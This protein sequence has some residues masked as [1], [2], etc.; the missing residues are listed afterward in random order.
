MTPTPEHHK[1]II[2]TLFKRASYA[3]SGTFVGKVSSALAG[4]IIARSLGV[5]LFGTYS[6]LWELVLLCASITETGLTIGIQRDGAGDRKRL[7][8]L[9]GNALFMRIVIGIVALVIAYFFSSKLSRNPQA[10][11]IYI[12][13]SIASLVVIVSEPL[14]SGMLALGRQK[15]VAAFES[16]RGIVLLVGVSILMLCHCGVIAL[17]MLQAA[18]YVGTLIV[19]LFISYRHYGLSINFGSMWHAFSTSFI[20]GIS[21]QLYSIYSRAPIVLLA[22]FTN[23]KQ[24]GYF[25]A[26]MRVVGIAQVIGGGMYSRAFVP[27]LFEYIKISRDKFNAASRFMFVYFTLLGA[28][29]G[30]G[31]FVLAEPIILILMGKQYHESI[32][33]LRVLAFAL[34][35]IFTNFAPDAAM[36]AGNKNVTKVLFQIFGPVAGLLSGPF[37]IHTFQAAGAAYTE[38]VIM[39]ILLTLFLT[40][41]VKEH[42]VSLKKL[43]Q[44]G[45]PIIGI[46]LC[47]AICLVVFKHSFVPLIAVF[48]CSSS[49]ILWL[50]IKR[51]K[52]FF[53][54]AINPVA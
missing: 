17:A 11:L 31:L 51:N 44:I 43:L 6:A 45:F 50:W 34:F 42:F 27:S 15:T 37:L 52:S 10:P 16:I 33:I 32:F 3:L 19:L 29:A 47:G 13:L 22:L 14:F 40:F 28:L 8:E 30:I 18:L 49:V 4:I 41:S 7:P 21:G 39:M 38:I 12:F 35:L 25:T 9:V 26:A 2:G 46:G 36:T 5:A 48:C 23:D 54:K 20:Y 24:V 1:D 53:Q